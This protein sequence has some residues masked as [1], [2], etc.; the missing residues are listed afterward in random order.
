MKEAK[1]TVS[2]KNISK[3]DQRVLLFPGQSKETVEKGGEFETTP[4]NAKDL[5]RM[6]PKSFEII[7]TNVEEAQ[8]ATDLEVEAEKTAVAHDI[9]DKVANETLPAIM[10]E[11]SDDE[12]AQEI[13]DNINEIFSEY[14]DE[15]HPEFKLTEEIDHVVVEDDLKRNPQLAEDGVKVGETIQLP[16]SIFPR[17]AVAVDGETPEEKADY[18]E[19]EKQNKALQELNQKLGEEVKLSEKEKTELEKQIETLTG[20]VEKSSIPNEV[21][22]DGKK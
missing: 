15:A 21:K 18:E 8:G 9:Y 16:K 19:L 6:Y 2:V 4:E 11:I 5:Q 22:K 14:L 12:I 3:S 10:A 7:G 1:T 17:P 13:L 20:S